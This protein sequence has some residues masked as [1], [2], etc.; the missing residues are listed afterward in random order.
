M[1]HMRVKEEAGLQELKKLYRIEEISIVFFVS[2]KGTSL[3]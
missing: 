3:T 2:K 1:M